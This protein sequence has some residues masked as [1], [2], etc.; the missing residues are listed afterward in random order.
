MLVELLRTKHSIWLLAGNIKKKTKQTHPYFLLIRDTDSRYRG[1]KVQSF[2]IANFYFLVDLF[3][4]FLNFIEC[5]SQGKKYNLLHHLEK[6]T[7]C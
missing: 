7:H 1:T 5:D 2:Q 6:Q 4:G 3:L